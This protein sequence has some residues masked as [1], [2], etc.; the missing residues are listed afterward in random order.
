MWLTVPS[1]TDSP[2]AAE[3]GGEGLGI[4][5]LGEARPARKESVIPFVVMLMPLG[6]SDKGNGRVCSIR[7]SLSRVSRGFSLCG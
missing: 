3:P 5:G 7:N 4:H 6:D 2:G 1:S